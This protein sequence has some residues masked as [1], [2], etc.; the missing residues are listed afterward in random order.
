MLLTASHSYVQAQLLKKI[1]KALDDISKVAGADS[2][3]KTR[4]ETVPTM[5]IGNMIMEAPGQNPGMKFLYGG[6]T[7]QEGS[8]DV[9]VVFYMEN[10]TGVQASIRIANYGDNASVAADYQGKRYSDMTIDIGGSQSKEGVVKELQ[11]GERMICSITLHNVPATV[12]KLNQVWIGCS[13]NKNMDAVNH[14]YGFRLKNVEITAPSTNADDGTDNSSADG[15]NGAGN[16]I[17]ATGFAGWRLGMPMSQLPKQV[18][19]L[20]STVNIE[21]TSPDSDIEGYWV[22]GSDNE[23]YV[24]VQALCDSKKTVKRITVFK[25]GI[26]INDAS[27]IHVSMPLASLK[28]VTGVKRIASGDYEDS[29]S[30][31]NFILEINMN[32]EINSITIK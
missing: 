1:G 20:Y 25:A 8:T 30:Y 5:K 19:G 26:K 31:K 23:E 29:Y 11:P 16:L 27:G 21:E 9:N 18:K 7:R 6:T 10:K 2:N 14:I 3:G 22:N 24:Q 32:N 13:T 15:N 4:Q 17:T 28:K 12:E